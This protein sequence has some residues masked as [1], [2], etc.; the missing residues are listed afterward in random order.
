MFE[1]SGRKPDPRR[2]GEGIHFGPERLAA[3]PN[4]GHGPS[5]V[6]DQWLLLKAS[7]HKHHKVG[8]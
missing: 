4:T 5:I 1:S 8:G 3:R 7:E 6:V 2:P